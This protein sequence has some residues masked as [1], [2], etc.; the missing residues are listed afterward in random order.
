MNLCDTNVISELTR[1]RPNSCVISWTA[2]VRSVAI[3]V[4]NPFI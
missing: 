1:R 4:V 2:G 3:S